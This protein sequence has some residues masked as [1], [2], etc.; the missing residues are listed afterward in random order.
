MEVNLA[1]SLSFQSNEFANRVALAILAGARILGLVA[2]LG[3]LLL[4]RIHASQKTSRWWMK[5][6]RVALSSPIGSH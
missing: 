3:T 6:R 2:I 5:W 4:R 1:R